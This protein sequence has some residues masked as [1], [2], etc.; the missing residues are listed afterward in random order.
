MFTLQSS[1][2][3]LTSFLVSSNVALRL[4]VWVRVHNAHNFLGL[5]DLFMCLGTLV[6]L[7]CTAMQ[8]YNAIYGMGGGVTVHPVNADKAVIASRKI[9]WCMIVIEK[10]AFGFVKLSI[11]FF[12][13]RIFGIWPKARR[14]NTALI[15]L[16]TVW[17]IAFLVADLLLCGVHPEFNWAYDQRVPRVKCGN[18]GALLL[19][20]AAT[21]VAT[22]AILLLLP[23]FYFQK[24][25]MPSRKRLAAMFV[26]FL[27]TDRDIDTSRAKGLQPDFLGHGGTL[28]WDLGSESTSLL[29]SAER[30]AS[31][32]VAA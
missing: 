26:F 9:D 22:D 24:L 25:K 21:S 18:K 6:A 17:T 10:P 20:F 27:G 31:I 16:V 11:L 2:T 13:R 8:F 5:D 28:A 12:Y 32:P 1:V 23:F 19:S 15:V 30:L 7:A 3:G 14:L 4:R 29:T